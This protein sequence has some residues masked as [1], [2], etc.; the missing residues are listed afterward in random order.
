M[1]TPPQ[2]NLILLDP[3]VREIVRYQLQIDDTAGFSSPLV[4]VTEDTG[5]ASPRSN[6]T[7][8]SSALGDGSYYW[9]VKTLD[10]EDAASDWTSANLGDIAF[11]LDA[12]GP[13]VPGTPST[14][15]PT[16]EI[17]PTWTFTASTDTGIGLDATQPYTF[18][19]C[20]DSG[21]IGCEAN[22]TTLTS[23]SYTHETPL[24]LGTWYVRVNAKR[25]LRKTHQPILQTGTV[26]I[27]S[28]N[29]FPSSDSSDTNTSA[30][31]CTDSPPGAKVP[32]LYGAIAQDSDS[33]LLY[34]TPSRFSGNHLCLGVR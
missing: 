7:Y 18:Q 6:V 16:S 9:R 2:Y 25:H 33:I 23:N 34:F 5:A 12:T 20:Q 24:A 19:W 26:T 11:K 1:I 30:P 21:F 3:D 14:T 4:D 8:T 27:M 15:T 22:T 13:T 31:T 29:S 10:D 28:A 17:R 32:W